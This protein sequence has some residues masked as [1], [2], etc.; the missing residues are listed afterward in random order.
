MNAFPTAATPSALTGSRNPLTAYLH[1][2][3]GLALLVWAIHGVA[4]SPLS[5]PA[6]GYLE[7]RIYTVTSNRLDA[8]LERFRDTVDPVRRRLGIRTIGYWSAPGVT[9]GGTFAYLMAAATREELQRQEKDFGADPQFRA[10]FAESNRKH[11][12]TVDAILSLPLVTEAA[13]SFPFPSS[14][15]PRAFELRIYSVLPG[16]LDAFRTRWRD[17]AVPLY[18]RHGLQS[19]GWWVAEPKDAAGHDQFVCMLAAPSLAAIPVAIASFH[20]DPEWQRAVKETEA[21]GPLRSGVIAYRLQATDFS[22]LK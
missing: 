13:A 16:K 12:K 6:A 15:S 8:V 20:Q 10:G 21:M 19:L 14:P 11:G 9:N 4:Q 3:L 18:E 5:A 7:F 17:V 2:L 22:R 1:R